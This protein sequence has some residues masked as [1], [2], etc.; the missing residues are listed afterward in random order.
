MTVTS[1]LRKAAC[2]VILAWV[3]V[4]PVCHAQTSKE[5]AG[6][7][8]GALIG[9]LLGST[10]GSGHGRTG[11]IIGGVV[12]GGMVGNLIGKHMDENDRRQM[13][14]ALESGPPGKPATWNNAD[15][16]ATYT[17]TPGQTYDQNGRQCRSFTQEATIDGEPKKISGTACRRPDDSTWETT[18]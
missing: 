10:I 18:G 3:A 9:G 13:N 16:G 11:A 2:A 1:S 4:M 15:T 8:G 12:L 5:T 17:V 14:N 6:T 7:L